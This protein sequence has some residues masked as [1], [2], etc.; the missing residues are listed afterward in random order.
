LAAK[1]KNPAR[2]KPKDARA[3]ALLTLLDIDA[4]RFPEDALEDYSSEYMA[5]LD[6]R[7]RALAHAL[8]F[9]VLRHRSRLDWTLNHFLKKPDKPLEPVIRIILWLGLFQLVH[10]DRIPAS[11]SVN[12]SVK[13]ARDYGP[14]WSV[15]LINGVLRAVTRAKALPDPQKANLPSIKKL[16]LAESH[17]EWMVRQW[18]NQLGYDEAAAFLNA[19]NQIPPLTLRVNTASISREELLALLRDRVDQVKPTFYSPEGLLI[20]GPTG[21]I[22]NLPGYSEGYFTIQDE[23]SQMVAHLARPR[24]GEKALDACAGRG[25]KALHLVSLARSSPV[26]ALD[27]DLAR[28]TH[29][30]PEARR[31]WL[32]SPIVVQGDL[33]HNPFKPESFEKVLLDAPCSSLG[34]IRRR[35]DIKWLKSAS[36]PPRLAEFQYKLLDAAA[37][38]VRPGG[39]LVYSVCTMTQEETSGC[40]EAFLSGHTNFKLITARDFLPP[41]A[42]PLVGPDRTLQTW[43]H[44]HQS[45]GFFAAVLKKGSDH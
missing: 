4:G 9:G 8:V 45:D 37:L 43:P 7:D 17:P 35:P 15:K 5:G 1:W 21:S 24:A 19:N 26:W 42:H 31:L 34:I 32:D 6:R 39:R 41:S 44:K 16:A 13:L 25:G 14:T 20:F 3:A 10:L 11:A 2:S 33:L 18:V 30:E 28:L 40:V 38:L 12:E 27:P 23:A 29:I 22:P 36:D